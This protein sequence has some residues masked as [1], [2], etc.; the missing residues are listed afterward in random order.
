MLEDPCLLTIGQLDGSQAISIQIV[1]PIVVLEPVPL[2]EL[3]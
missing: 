3:R 1:D 2:S